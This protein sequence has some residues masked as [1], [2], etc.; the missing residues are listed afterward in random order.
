ML[1]R[2]VVVRDGRHPH[3]HGD[4]RGVGG[5]QPEVSGVRP[6]TSTGTAGSGELAQVTRYYPAADWRGGA[7]RSW[8]PGGRPRSGGAAPGASSPSR[9]PS[10]PW[11][12][13]RA[14]LA[15]APSA[16][17]PPSRPA[18]AGPAGPAP[19]LVF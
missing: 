18:A 10:T 19:A 2:L 17:P 5:R 6:T 16:G 4:V 12:S 14:G 15:S 11:P 8:S 1:T 9:T 13:A 3:M 7:P